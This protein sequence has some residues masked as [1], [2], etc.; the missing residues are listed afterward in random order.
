MFNLADFNAAYQKAYGSWEET[1][2]KLSELNRFDERRIK[3]DYIHAEELTSADNLCGGN[4]RIEVP[5]EVITAAICSYRISL[6]EDL[7]GYEADIQR[8]IA[9]AIEKPNPKEFHITTG[10]IS[11][12]IFTKSLSAVGSLDVGEVTAGTINLGGND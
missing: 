8:L 4:Q 1:N 5:S 10:K 11:N 6:E 3:D 7:E 9:K 2:D 12:D